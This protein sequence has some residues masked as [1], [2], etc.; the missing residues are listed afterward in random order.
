MRNNKNNWSNCFRIKLRR[1]KM[2]LTSSACLSSGDILEAVFL[3]KPRASFSSLRSASLSLQRNSPGSLSKHSWDVVTWQLSR[4]LSPFNSF[5]LHRWHPVCS[6]I[7][8]LQA[9]FRQLG[10][11]WVYYLS[12]W[13]DCQLQLQYRLPLQ[14]QLRVRLQLKLPLVPFVGSHWRLAHHSHHHLQHHLQY[15]WQKLA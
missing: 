8:F 6:L 4:P 2:F 15:A 1:I 13:L 5:V 7:S 11:C 3:G 9:R 10:L 14:L 12:C